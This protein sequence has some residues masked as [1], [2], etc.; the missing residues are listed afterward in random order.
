[1]ELTDENFFDVIEYGNFLILAYTEWCSL[2]PP[3]IEKLEKL[4]EDYSNFTFAKFHFQD[5]PKA[6]KKL[7]LLGVP[8]VICTKDG[9]VQDIRSGY[10]DDYYEMLENF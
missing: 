3:T 10:R 7:G 1:M 8:A 9:I 5:C 4:E 6:T 2:C